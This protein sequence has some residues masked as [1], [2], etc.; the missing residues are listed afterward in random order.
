MRNIISLENG[1]FISTNSFLN[2]N[3]DFFEDKFD[4]NS[5]YNYIYNNLEDISILNNF[6][7]HKLK[8]ACFFEKD[9]EEEK[10]DLLS[11]V[12]DIDDW[13]KISTSI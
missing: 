6:L 8:L 5:N 2:M 13:R 7:K 1:K 9:Q 10:L 12:I 4:N 11:Q 3:E